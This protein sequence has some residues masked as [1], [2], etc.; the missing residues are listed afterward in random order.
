MLI[1]AS[2]AFVAAFLYAMGN[3]LEKRA[4]DDMHLFALRSLKQAIGQILRSI[5]WIG[6][7]LAS[8]IGSF[9]QIF[10]YHFASISIVQSVGVAGVVI[11]VVASR[12]HFHEHLQ[13][14]EMSGLGIC[15]IA[16]L[17][18]MISIYGG[19]TRPGAKAAYLPV[20]LTIV[21]TLLG[22]GLLL[23]FRS[24]RV[25]S[26]D[27][28]YGV[29]SGLMYG[30]VGIS[31][32]GLSTVLGKGS[33]MNVVVSALTTPYLYLMIISWFFALMIF[34]A[35]LQSGRVG[36]ITPLSGA[37][38]AIFVTAVGTPLFGE[39]FPQS[40]GALALRIIGF[41][42]VLLGSC[43]LAAGGSQRSVIEV[44]SERA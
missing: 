8:V 14:L 30:I 12:L 6:G 20:M 31:S 44:I 10:A 38:T 17:L 37:I 32:K 9:V 23:M 16:F 19:G 15:V 7:A 42:G 34:Q 18:T 13:P 36:V 39:N 5:G 25:R 1:G 29:S 3:V 22:V 43:M 26:G 33:A 41:L 21:G 35:G 28:T 40:S 27:F 24:L 11:V 4:V 2:L